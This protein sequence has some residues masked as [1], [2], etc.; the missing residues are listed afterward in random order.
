MATDA[1]PLGPDLGHWSW[2]LAC[3]H[4][5][6]P[7]YTYSWPLCKASRFGHI[8][9]TRSCT[10]HICQTY[11]AHMVNRPYIQVM[12]ISGPRCP[13]SRF[14]RIHISRSCTS[15]MIHAVDLH[16]VDLLFFLVKV[17]LGRPEKARNSV[18]SICPAHANATL[19]NKNF[20]AHRASALHYV[21]GFFLVE[22]NVLQIGCDPSVA[23]MH[24]LH[25]PNRGFALHYAHGKLLSAAKMSED[26]V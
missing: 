5:V 2:A 14:G 20:S 16:I 4:H 8:D 7:T 6:P 1:Q 3:A 19:G 11:V 15:L 10:V 21:H 9:P 18:S 12:V 23:L 13:D 26:S 22:L 24:I 17:F 25:R